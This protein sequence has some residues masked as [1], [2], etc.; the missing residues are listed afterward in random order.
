MGKRPLF[1]AAMVVMAVTVLAP[2]VTVAGNGAPNGW[3]YNLNIIGV[4]NPKTAPMDDTSRHTIFVPLQGRCDIGLRMGDYSVLDG[5]C[6]DGDRAEFQLPDPNTDGDAYA[7]YSVWMRAT[8]PK[9][10]ASMRTCYTDATGTWCNAGDLVLSIAKSTKFVDVSK[11]LLTVCYDQDPTDGIDLKK[12]ALFDRA[13]ED[14][15]W[16]YENDGLRHVQFRFY[17][18]EDAV[19]E[20][21]GD[22]C[23]RAPG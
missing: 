13:L 22:S 5:N 8:G 7:E 19:S 6:T 15:F 18:G 11:Q 16:R 12:E 23:T 21:W 4:E 14:L 20:N 2:A 1:I 10:E 9:G 3:H 17:P